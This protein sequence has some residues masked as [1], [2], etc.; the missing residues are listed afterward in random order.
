MRSALVVGLNLLSTLNDTDGVFS[1][2]SV[3]VIEAA[4]FILAAAAV[5]GQL[6]AARRGVGMTALT[7]ATAFFAL[8]LVVA[9]SL[10]SIFGGGWLGLP[11]GKPLAQNPPG[12]NAFTMLEG[13]EQ[14]ERRIEYARKTI[15]QQLVVPEDRVVPEARASTPTSTHTK[16]TYKSWSKFTLRGTS[17]S[18]TRKA[19]RIC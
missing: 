1:R 12:R 3:G 7:L 9:A 10:I 5:L 4:V 8:G 13:A 6:D 18:L 17:A 14:G 15:A 19:T 2:R 11:A 16:S